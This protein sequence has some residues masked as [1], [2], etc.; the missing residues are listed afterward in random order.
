MNCIR[1]ID[2]WYSI[3]CRPSRGR[4]L[5]YFSSS[6]IARFPLRLCL[7]SLARSSRVEGDRGILLVSCELHGPMVNSSVQ[8]NVTY[9]SSSINNPSPTTTTTTNQNQNQW[10]NPLGFVSPRRHI[11][12]RT[13]TMARMGRVGRTRTKGRRRRIEEKQRTQHVPTRSE[14]MRSRAVSWS[15]RCSS[16][17]MPLLPLPINVPLAMAMATSA[18]V[19]VAVV[20]TAAAIANR[21]VPSSA[22][23]L[24]FYKNKCA[25]NKKSK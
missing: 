25:T 20:V 21:K 6:L 14:V 4:P 10:N 12:T 3:E 22:A 24:S 5:I 7:C 11:L 19:V 2:R 13:R 23:R 17:P 15:P 1:R 16:I 18:L 9:I 8:E